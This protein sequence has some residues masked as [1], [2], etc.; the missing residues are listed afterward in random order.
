VFCQLLGT[1]AVAL[2][3]QPLID[4]MPIADT[5]R[6]QMLLDHVY[7]TGEAVLGAESLPIHTERDLVYWN[8]SIWPITDTQR[9]P[10]GLVLLIQDTTAHHHD[11]QA[12]IDT[13]AA[14]EQLLI[15]SLRELEV[16]E[17]LRHQLAFTTAITTSL[18]EGLYTLDRAGLFTMV[19]PAA[20][21][22]LGRTEVD[23]IGRSVYEVMYNLVATRRGSMPDNVSEGAILPLGTATRDENARWMRRDGV[24]FPAAYSTAPILVD[25]Q[26]V[27]TVVSFRD[28]TEV[29]QVA[30]TLAQQAIVLA[31]SRAELEQVLVDVRALALND[32]LTGLYNRRG[33][34]TLAAQHMKLA[35]R[36]KHALSLIFIDLD[37]LKGINDRFGHTIGSQ[38]IADTAHMLSATF[39]DSDIIARYGVM[40]LWY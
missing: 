11:E 6:I 27:G 34:L 28:L 16:A 33:F 20:E 37:G 35:K 30:L 12:V 36:T 18:G 13:H 23:L 17:Q 15:T 38:A 19:N 9:R 5:D 1:D 40:S 39:R 14:N 21:R 24:L 10:I 3:G 22:I 29:Q 25:S 2:L 8:Y 4:V 32:E 26:V 31:R 7:Q